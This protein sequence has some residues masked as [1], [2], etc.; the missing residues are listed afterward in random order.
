MNIPDGFTPDE[1]FL[2]R[3]KSCVEIGNPILDELLKIED[4]AIFKTIISTCVDSWAT[5]KGYDVRD[6]ID[7]IFDGIH[8]LNDEEEEM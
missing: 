6:I 8:E 4:P 7:D 1:K 2:E 5:E 3:L